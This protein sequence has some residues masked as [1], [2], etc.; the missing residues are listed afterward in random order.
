VKIKTIKMAELIVCIVFPCILAISVIFG[1]WYLPLIMIAAAMV[2]F[3]I[4]LSRTREVI[5]DEGTRAIDDKAGNAALTMGSI[6]MI[7]AGAILMAVS[8]D[9]SSG[10][11]IA[12]ITLY[13]AAIGLSIMN[14][15]TKLYFKAK[16][17]AKNE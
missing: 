11:G 5:E 16:L 10:M 15:F 14:Y 7:L 6:F 17:G 9:N 3:G 8:G 2:L 4:L 13:G 1:I 12:A